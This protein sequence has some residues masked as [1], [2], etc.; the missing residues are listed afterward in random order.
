VQLRLYTPPID[1][2]NEHEIIL[3]FLNLGG[4]F[5]H[6]RKPGQALKSYQLWLGKLPAAYHSKIILHEWHSLTDSY[7]LGGVHLRTN[8]RLELE[9]HQ[10]LENWL[11]SCKKKGLICGTAVHTP[12]ELA[13]LSNN[14]DYTSVSPV[15]P[16]IS[17]VGYTSSVDWSFDETKLHQVALGGI[18]P[19]KL[20]I[21]RKKGFSSCAIMGAIWK[22]SKPE[23]ALKAFFT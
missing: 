14:F 4:Q 2:Q 12:E 8:Q 17:K 19:S 1:V 23:E 9:K 3:R 21:L 11:L 6:L 10:T 15:F 7:N 13:L 20:S 16:S 22:Q 5:V 18:D